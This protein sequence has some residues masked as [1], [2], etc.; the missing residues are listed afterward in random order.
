[1]P[2]STLSIVVVTK[3]VIKLANPP[4]LAFSTYIKLEL[5]IVIS[6]NIVIISIAIVISININEVKTYFLEHWWKF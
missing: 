6:M 5:V 3:M 1:M 2:S 4:A